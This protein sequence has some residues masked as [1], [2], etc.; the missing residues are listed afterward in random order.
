[1]KLLTK[2]IEAK[3]P[4]LYATDGVPVEDKTV[5]VKFFTP[6][7]NWTWYAFEGER[8]EDGDFLFFGLVTGFATE[9]GYFSLRE[10]EGAKGPFGLGI[11]RDL[12]FEGKVPEADLPN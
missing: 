7:A 5:A 3:I 8:T 1:M 2:A 4:K 6:W 12:H 9:L 10:L 11:E